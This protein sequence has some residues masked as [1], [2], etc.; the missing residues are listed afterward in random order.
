MVY[1]KLSSGNAT[2]TPTKRTPRHNPQ[3][4]RFTSHPFTQEFTQ[5]W[6]I[7]ALVGQPIQLALEVANRSQ[8]W[9]A[10]QL[11]LGCQAVRSGPHQEQHMQALPLHSQP[12]VL[13]IGGT[14]GGGALG[15]LTSV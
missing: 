9:H 13:C 8:E 5:P 4:P 2:T 15:S 14:S 3:N 6:G 12:D 7:E 11:S 10:M 1:L